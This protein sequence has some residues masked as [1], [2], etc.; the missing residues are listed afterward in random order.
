MAEVAF[1]GVYYFG[2]ASVAMAEGTRRP[3]MEGNRLDAL[4]GFPS[5]NLHHL[6]LSRS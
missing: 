3:K 5:K 6:L 4:G 1:V 2:A